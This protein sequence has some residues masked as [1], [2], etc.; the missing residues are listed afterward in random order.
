MKTILCVDDI[1]ANLF[2]LNALFEIHCEDDYKIETA[3]SGKEALHVLLSQKI[4]MILLD[5]M[6]P[7]MDGYETASLILKNRKTKDIPIIFLTAKKDD[8]TVSKC[9]EAG[10]VDYLSKPYNAQE[11]LVRIDFHFDL[12][13]SKKVLEREKK[14]NQDILDMQ[15][16]L[17][18]V[19]NGKEVVKIN[20]AVSNFYNISD[21]KEFVDDYGCVCNSFVVEEGY[22]HLEMVPSG[23]VWI[24]VLLK[25][26]KTKDVLV[27]IKDAKSSKVNSFDIKAK[28]FGID[29]LITLTN[30]TAFDA[31]SK[32]NEHEASYDSLTNIYNR[33]K[34]QELFLQ[35]IKK[36]KESKTTFSFVMMDIDFFKAVNDTHGHLVGDD[37]LIQITKLIK[38]H[39]R[40]NDIFARWGGE[41]FALILSNVGIQRAEVIANNLRVKIESEFFPEVQKITC[42]FGLTSYTVGDTQDNMTQRADIALYDAKDAGRNRVCSLA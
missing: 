14:L 4:D 27:L 39:I 3:L 25:E 37:V 6:M 12:I 2:T 28:Y 15:D 31:E 18:I 13:D 26:L 23:E 42:S 24:D 40:E 30:I 1:Q 8:D 34:L 10:G 33:N 16:N 36:A 29:Y 19:S 7:E 38:R 11:L 20:K 5:V 32:L 41:E 17:V 21:I 35:Q 9:Y 22:F